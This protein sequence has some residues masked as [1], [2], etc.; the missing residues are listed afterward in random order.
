MDAERW[1]RID[2]LL[3]AALQV[4]VEQQEEFLRQ[5]C[6][7]DADLLEEVDSLLTSHRQA[8]SFLESPAFSPADMPT[9]TADPASVG[10]TFRSMV[11]ET[12]T[13]YR[14]LSRLGSGGM[15]V[16]YEAEDIKLGRRVAMKFLPG[17]VASD[18]TA[19]E[20]MQREARSASAL[21]HPNI[22]SIYE[23]G[24]HDG[25]PFIVMQLLEGE[26]LRGWIDR[27]SKM[28]KDSRLNGVIDLAIQI[29][30]GLEAAHQKNIIHRDIKPENIFVTVR[31]E[32]KIL[33]FGLA[34]VME[35]QKESDVQSDLTADT[36]TH[37]EGSPTLTRTGAKMGTAFYMSPEQIRGEKLDA[38]SDLFSLGLV[39]F[40]M[41]T[42]RRA[43]RGSTG[44][45]VHD[46]VLHGSPAPV[47]QINPA[48]P[49]GLESVIRRSLERD[50]DCRYQSARE[51][52]ADLELS[53]R[54]S[55]SLIGI[56]ASI[57]AGLLLLALVALGTNV[58]GLR[59]R[60]LHRPARNGAAEQLRQRTAVAVLGFK[61]LSG[62]DDE[63]WISTALSEMLDA[64]LSAGQQLRVVSGEDVARMKIDLSLPAADSYS[65]STLKRIRT[66]LGSDIVVLG[67]YLDTGKDNGGKIRVD[68]RL[69]DARQGET[70]AV[71]SQD[72]NEA[73]LPELVTQS[74][75]GLRQKLGIADVSATEASQLAASASANPE[76]TR[77]YAEGLAK[78]QAYE[79]LAARDL[80]EKA[81]AADPNYAL[82][83]SA[84]AQAWSQL[85]YDKKAEEAAK[86]AFDLSAN[87][88]REQHLSVE[89]RDREFAH[90]FP[91]AIE[92]YR[93]LRNFFPDNLDYAL[94][95][96]SSQ[97]KAGRPKDSLETIAQVR[98]L[99]KPLS[100]DARI[101]VE[102]ASAQNAA[103]NFGAL[104]EAAAAA[105]AKAKA[106]GSR[107]LQVQATDAEAFAWDRLG[108]LN[109]AVQK[110]LESRDLAANAGN[111][112][113]LGH[114]LRTYGIVL[115]DKG[116][117]AGARSAFEQALKI[118]QEI[119]D[120]IE[121]GHAAVSLGNV[122]Y[123]QGK[124]EEARRY[125]E[126]ALRIHQEI[127]AQPA[128]IGSDLGSIANVLDNLGD[129]VS[130]ARMQEQSLQGF[131][132][133][134]DQR[135]VT[136]TLGN[137]AN[138]L[139]ERGDLSH[140]MSYYDEG[141]SLA[142]KIGY[143]EGRAFNL[144]GLAQISLIRD[145]VSQ[146]R[147][148]EEQVLRIQKELGDSVEI[149]RSQ[150]ALATMA[151]EEGKPAEA[152]ALLRA[153][154]PQFEQ[155]TMAT[156][157]S[158]SAALLARALLAQSK[159]A[160]AQV[161]AAHA[162][163]LAER[164]S[165][166]STHL[167]ATLAAAEVNARTGKEPT[168]TK[169]LQ[170]VLSESVRDGYKEFEF[171]ARLDLGRLELHSSRASGRQRLE[172]LEEDAPRKDFR[173]MARKAREELDR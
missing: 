167:L 149:A 160:D 21:D 5:Q 26:T 141:I 89:G 12:V 55:P 81:V 97:R 24:E 83:H 33:D 87:L 32:V 7:G 64:Q 112:H 147:D 109:K 40:E 146:A 168:A 6:A 152:E 139:V 108:D 10:V 164:T 75:A 15:G 78:L 4:P 62:R 18:R 96:A 1:K 95:L 88:T 25:Q 43:F 41:L 135:G 99:P 38:R 115:Y 142:E 72:G 90:D 91:S 122:Y 126:Q 117:F 125:Y 34:K 103:G 74:S 121:I 16:V 53:L 144:D 69:Q 98:T 3:Q 102:E 80:L 157:A 169:A 50:R 161:A 110:S 2:E 137:L 86:K 148:Q 150:I 52:R 94:R 39:L 8:G 154:G 20:R 47:R 100:D 113:L 104:Q 35:P 63:A 68:V 138:V 130:A 29:T 93:T 107:M 143:K 159:I 170:S 118:F 124:L 54:R 101:D 76:A 129:L 45:D 22:C 42:G 106:Q 105:A 44:A 133:G 171:E 70:I 59:D 92:I 127:G 116:D 46:A 131:R 158:Q 166:R 56:A 136:A 30:R 23:L 73:N 153:A 134:G 151:I 156:G 77:L 48:V 162:L 67:S 128:A 114:A 85:G 163:A 31:G 58:G 120:G 11:G 57:A 84:L 65:R 123:D 155:Q 140:A 111:P 145:Q 36:V 17:E 82:S 165:D 132:D 60:V 27:I 61:N 71:I 13:H 79:A 37:E 19:F 172:Q 119:G 49:S 66:H 9:Q 51:L 28:D 14:V 173:L